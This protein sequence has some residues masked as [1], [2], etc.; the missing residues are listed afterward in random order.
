MSCPHCGARYKPDDR[1]SGKKVRCKRCRRSF[2]ADDKTG[3]PA[4]P[5][6]L[7]APEGPGLPPTAS[8]PKGKSPLRR[9]LMLGAGLLAVGVLSL[10]A[11]LLLPGGVDQE[12]TDLKGADPGKRAAALEWLA[13]A[14]PSDAQR[15]KV[16]A[17]LEPLLFDG[18]V[19]KALS[20]DLL[21]HAY[22]QWADK[23]NVP[24]MTRMVRNPTLPSWGPQQTGLV[25]EAL[26]RLGDERAADALAEKLTDPDLHDRAVDAL[27]VMGPK[28][29][30]AVLDY[31]F[32][33]DPD[34]RLRADRLL[35]DYGTTPETAAAEAVSRLRSKQADVRRGAVVWFLDNLPPDEATKAE[36]APL[37]ASLLE[38]PSPEARR[39]ALE[40]L[41]L[42]ATENCLPQLLEHARR[43]QTSP[44]GEP[45]LLDVLA[46]FKEKAAAEAIALRLPNEKA[47]ARAAQDLLKV[48]PAATE[49]VLPYL[50]YPDDGVRNAA[51]DLF[52][53]LNVSDE[54]RI[55]QALA[56][57][58]GGDV[59]RCRLA[60]QYLAQLR[61]DAASRPKVSAALNTALLDA[62]AGIREDALN[63]VLVWGTKENTATLIKLL[64]DCSKEGVGGDGR[65]AEALGSIQDAA[66]APALVQG[67]TDARERGL[68]GKAFTAIGPG[69][70]EAVIPFLQS[71]GRGARLEACRV[72]AEIGTGKSLG[73]LQTAV[74]AYGND[75]E[76]V[77]EGFVAIERINARLG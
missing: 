53:R 56:D 36:A 48:G 44:S 40:A 74:Y 9:R 26:G 31:L 73:P 51:R 62:D 37:L 13:A 24:A 72:L 41:K 7:P 20:P 1:L 42:W 12:L 15:A 23:N 50:D 77:R 35:E 46:Q 64:G 3:S 49:A 61:P 8:R 22:L 58:A 21:L 16:T 43:G 76:F 63:A 54:G 10:L 38:D 25:M 66:A 14:D 4:A 68:V 55:E 19:R 33:E 60:L 57:V 30:G 18:D 47:R 29:E 39:Q 28:A 6:P 5:P 11:Y 2:L 69:A 34:V 65:V 75:G 52:Q 17:A 27:D 59:A 71:E 32:D 70:E 45:L 67:L